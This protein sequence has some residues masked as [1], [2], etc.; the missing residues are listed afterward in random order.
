MVLILSFLYDV[1]EDAELL[2]RPRNDTELLT[3]EVGHLQW[4]MSVQ[5]YVMNEGRIPLEAA[6]DGRRCVFGTWFYGPN[7]TALEQEVP[8]LRP[9]FAVL[10]QKHLALHQSA[11]VIRTDMERGESAAAKEHFRTVSLPLLTEVRDL[12]R[13]SLALTRGAQSGIVARLEGKLNDITRMAVSASLIFLLAGL[14]IAVLL[15]FRIPYESYNEGGSIISMFLSPA[16]AC[17]A[18][19]IYGKIQILKKKL[20]ADF[21]RVHGGLV[22]LYSQRM[23]PVPPVRTGRGHD[24]VAAAQVGHHSDRHQHLRPPWG[25][26]SHHCSGGTG[27]RCHGKRAGPPSSSSCFG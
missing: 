24:G 2:G 15:L 3:A 6:L 18:V 20:A 27:H 5:D 13:N 4:A 1:G 9:L 21:S 22:Y 16:T 14:T 10:D 19:A 11:G 7:R 26:G 25:Y 23:A 12:L 8:D 17:L